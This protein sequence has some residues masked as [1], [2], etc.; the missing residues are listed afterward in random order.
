ME[1]NFG[2]EPGQIFYCSWGYDQT[3]INFYEVVRVTATKA[4][5]QPI[6]SGG[7]G[8]QKVVARPGVVREWDVLIDLPAKSGGMTKLCKVVDK[9]TIV[10]RS[11]HYWAHR[12][13]GSPKYETD[14]LFGH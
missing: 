6:A 8:Y 14:I 13:D 4:E 9:N 11:G 2:V 7:V 1:N 10:L 3:N 12:Y 5:I